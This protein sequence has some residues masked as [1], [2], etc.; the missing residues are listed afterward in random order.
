MP[1]DLDRVSLTGAI[2]GLR[3][4][5][6]EAAKKAQKLEPGAPRFRI[7]GV[8][9]ELTVVAED[10]TTAGVEASW[11][12][13]KAKADLAAKDAVTHK[14]KLS[15]NVGDIEIDSGMRPDR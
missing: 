15:L 6:M 11:W 13:F 1:N 9:I 3:R 14:V 4:Q 10:S 12:V 2:D 7:T 8:E 5:I